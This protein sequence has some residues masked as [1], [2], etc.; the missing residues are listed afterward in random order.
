[1]YLKNV[2]NEIFVIWKKLFKNISKSFFFSFTNFNFK[3]VPKYKL[4]KKEFFLFTSQI[5]F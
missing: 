3:I 4:F 2:Q 5:F 1:M